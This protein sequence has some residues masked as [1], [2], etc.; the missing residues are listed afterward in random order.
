MLIIESK[1]NS[2]FSSQFILNDVCYHKYHHHI[3]WQIF[4]QERDRSFTPAWSIVCLSQIWVEADIQ[5]CKIVL[6]APVQVVLR[7]S[8]C[9]FHPD[10]VFLLPPEKLSDNLPLALG[11][12]LATW[13]NKYNGFKW[14]MWSD[15]KNIGLE[16]Q[17]LLQIVVLCKFSAFSSTML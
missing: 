15:T 7:R 12:A 14:V 10:A 11:E 4:F 13:P 9:Y 5:L 1:Y 3:H 6:H 2:A 16:S 17:L 8:F